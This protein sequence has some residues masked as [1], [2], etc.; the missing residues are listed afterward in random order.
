MEDEIDLKKSLIL[1]K[2]VLLTILFL[3]GSTSNFLKSWFRLNQ[4]STKNANN[5]TIK[6]AGKGNGDSHVNRCPFKLV[7]DE[8]FFY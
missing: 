7:Y 5:A 3:L 6:S 1:L 2:S 8:M 4:P